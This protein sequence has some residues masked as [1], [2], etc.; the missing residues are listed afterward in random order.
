MSACIVADKTVL[1]AQSTTPVLAVVRER[2]GGFTKAKILVAAK[3]R[4]YGNAMGVSIANFQYRV[5]V[6]PQAPTKD[7]C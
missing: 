2:A 5:P 6:R 1:A 7:E 4:V 3:L